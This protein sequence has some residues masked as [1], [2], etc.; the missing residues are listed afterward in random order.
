MGKE[1]IGIAGART[2][3]EVGYI[4]IF[5][6]GTTI[7]LKVEYETDGTT[8]VM[9]LTVARRTDDKMKKYFG[10]AGIP[11]YPWYHDNEMKG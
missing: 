3:G 10:P 8:A 2:G 9:E 6:Y 1:F 5:N 11:P 7:S 4:D